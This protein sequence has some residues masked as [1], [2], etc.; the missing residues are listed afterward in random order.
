MAPVGIERWIR[1]RRH[2]THAV[3]AITSSK[4]HVQKAHFRKPVFETHGMAQ[5]T[6][7]GSYATRYSHWL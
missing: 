6:L 3:T 2:G 5:P 4:T 1:T 7:A